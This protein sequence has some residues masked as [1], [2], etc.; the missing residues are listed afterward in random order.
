[1]FGGVLRPP[2]TWAVV[3]PNGQI[4][5]LASRR[6][7]ITTVMLERAI[8]PAAMAGWRS[9]MKLGTQETECNTPAATGT[10]ATL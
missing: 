3:P 4:R 10:R 1:M 5:L 2:A 9:L 6:L 8:A 7:F